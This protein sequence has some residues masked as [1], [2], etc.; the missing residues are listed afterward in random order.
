MQHNKYVYEQ[1]TIMDR[2]LTKMLQKKY[3]NNQTIQK[4][5]EMIYGK[6]AKFNILDVHIVWS[7]IPLSNI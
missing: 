7:T 3:I 1:V 6:E 4:N 5:A 2:N